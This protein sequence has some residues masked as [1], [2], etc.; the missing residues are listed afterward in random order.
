[1]GLRFKI[2]IQVLLD[3]KAFSGLVIQ[4]MASYKK[5]SPAEF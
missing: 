4:M 5:L 2:Q 1:M 3:Q